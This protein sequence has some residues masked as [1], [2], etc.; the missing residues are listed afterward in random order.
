[1]GVTDQG[2]PAELEIRPM[3]PSAG[4]LEL[5]ANC[6]AKNSSP[7]RPDAMHW[8]Y[9]ANPTGRMFVDFAL[10]PDARLAAL[11]ATLP[12]RFRI[13]GDVALAMQSVDTI[14]DADY[15]GRGLFLKLAKSTYARAAADGAKLVYGFPNGNSV[16]G[17][18]ERLEWK[19]LDPVPFLIRPLRA[20]Y[21]LNQLK[22]GRLEKFVPNIPLHLGGGRAPRHGRIETI[23]SFD[24]RASELWERFSRH[25]GVAVERDAAYLNW[26]LIEKPGEAYENLGYFDD[27]QLSAIVSHV[28][29][30]KHGGRIGYLMESLCLDGCEKQLRTLMSRALHSMLKHGADVVLAWCL[31][32]SPTFSTFLRSGFLPFPVKLRPIELHFGAR[33]L[34]PA[35]AALVGERRNWYLSYLDADT[36]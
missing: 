1:M 9:I 8:Q 19:N 32:S 12:V 7:R 26:R 14:T 33:S 25:V 5:F 6:F 20:S 21:V 10:A 31:P 11:Y 23:R 27:E 17:F 3:A 24:E 4:D 30:E 16:H 2:S 15:R 28:V 18:F 34:D 36:T 29:K 22:L 35:L 13:A